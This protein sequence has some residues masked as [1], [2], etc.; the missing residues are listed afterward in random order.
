MSPSLI[1]E[2]FQG[3]RQLR[4]IIRQIQGPAVWPHPAYSFSSERSVSS[5]ISSNVHGFGD[6]FVGQGLIIR[7]PGLLTA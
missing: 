7:Y 3:L 6:L 4:L 2:L 5:L 1:Q